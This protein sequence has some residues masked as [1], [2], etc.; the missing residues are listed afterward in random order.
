MAAPES[1]LQYTKTRT[2]GRLTCGAYTARASTNLAAVIR[3]LGPLGPNGMT[4]GWEV[5]CLEDRCWLSTTCR[6]VAVSTTSGW[7]LLHALNQSL[8]HH[9]AACRNQTLHK[10]LL[11]VRYFGCTAVQRKTPQKLIHCRHN[12]KTFRI[13]RRSYSLHSA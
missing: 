6:G 10:A 5:A 4:W 9:H 12:P 7:R 1:V 8:R 11:Q 2:I 13:R 3:P